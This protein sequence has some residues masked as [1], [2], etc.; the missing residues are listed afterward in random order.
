MEE[1][2]L[3]ARK[4]KCGLCMVIPLLDMGFYGS[5]VVV[6]DFWTI[7]S[8]GPLCIVATLFQQKTL[9]ATNQR[10]VNLFVCRTIPGPSAR[11]GS[12]VWFSDLNWKLPWIFLPKEPLEYTKTTPETNSLCWWWQLTYFLIFTRNYLGKWFPIWRT[13]IFFK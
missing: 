8:R 6:W 7:N 3:P 11:S 4:K 12:A 5:Q 1:I 2:P 10:D 9:G 13:R